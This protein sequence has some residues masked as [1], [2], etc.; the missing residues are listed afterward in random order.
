MWTAWA[1]ILPPAFWAGNQTDEIVVWTVIL[2]ILKFLI[3]AQSNNTAEL[4]LCQPEEII[5]IQVRG[6]RVLSEN[7]LKRKRQRERKKQ[8]VKGVKRV[9]KNAQES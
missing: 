1:N 7:R 6:E 8:E 5:T 9:E 2:S 4:K 3:N